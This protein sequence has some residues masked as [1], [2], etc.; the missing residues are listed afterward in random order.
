MLGVLGM[1]THDA[2]RPFAVYSEHFEHGSKP[3]STHATLLAAECEASEWN[4]LAWIVD[5][6]GKL[7]RTFRDKVRCTSAD[8]FRQTSQDPPKPLTPYQLETLR[9]VLML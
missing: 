8:P 1:T 5:A 7:A 4:G 2:T 9:R 3:V 6:Q